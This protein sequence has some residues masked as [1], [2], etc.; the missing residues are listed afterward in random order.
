MR[1][2][3]LY[4][5]NNNLVSD[6]SFLESRLSEINLENP[7]NNWEKYL[8]KG[9]ESGYEKVF[10]KLESQSPF[11][12]IKYSIY[13]DDQKNQEIVQDSTFL[14]YIV[15]RYFYKTSKEEINEIDWKENIPLEIKHKGE[16]LEINKE[17][18]IDKVP[19]F[20]EENLQLEENIVNSIKVRINPMKKV[21][22]LDAS[23]IFL[24]SDGSPCTMKDLFLEDSEKVYS[25]PV[26]GRDEDH[27]YEI[28]KEI[29]KS[30]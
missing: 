12:R 27:T 19:K 22:S 14:R 1:S 24:K 10:L 30:N 6:T 3:N 29:F 16:N 15:P 5:K 9:K 11:F 17:Y 18:L 8:L 21:F 25:Y 13:F 20:L 26:F 28:L 23:I 7:K 4:C 2:L